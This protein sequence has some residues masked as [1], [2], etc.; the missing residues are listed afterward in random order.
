MVWAIDPDTKVV[1]K[2]PPRSNK[3][4]WQTPVIDQY[5]GCTTVTVY[6]LGER[7]LPIPSKWLP[8]Y[9]PGQWCRGYTEH[10]QNG[11]QLYCPPPDVDPDSEAGKEMASYPSPLAERRIL[12]RMNGAC[13]ALKRAQARAEKSRRGAQIERAL[14]LVYKDDEPVARDQLQ[15]LKDGL[16]ALSM[17]FTRHAA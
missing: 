7:V 10:R 17:Y 2:Y 11:A 16:I 3:G 15:D 6:R 4:A 13:A 9:V 14:R 12:K 5:P 8:E 1:V